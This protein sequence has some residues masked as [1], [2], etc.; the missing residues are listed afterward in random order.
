MPPLI[1]V[2]LSGGS[3]TRLWPLSREL[4]PKQ[5]LPLV[6]SRTLLQETLLRTKA[7][8][9][10]V[11]PPIVVCSV[12]HR[13]ILAEQL[14][15]IEVRPA[16]IVLEP[17]GRNTAPALAVA[18]LLAAERLSGEEDPLLVVLPAD[19][20]IVD[21]AAF[22]RAVATAADVA[23]LGRIVAFGIVPTGPETG[24]GYLLRGVDHG[25]WSEL[26]RFVEKP[27]FETASRFV[28]SGRY[29]WNSG[30]FLCSARTYLNELAQ[31]APPI[32]AACERAVQAADV[33]EDFTRL[34]A[35]FLDCPSSSIDY[36]V[37]EK[38]SKAAVVALDAGWSDIGSWATL[39]E[40]IGKDMDGNAF[41]GDVVAKECR[42]SYIAASSRLVAA[43][44][45]DGFVIVETADAVLV[46]P[47]ERAQS[48]KIIVDHLKQGGRA[49][50]RDAPPPLSTQ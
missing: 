6:T 26:E 31:H 23:T 16:M 28:E 45:L 30:M 25:G 34:G 8:E 50:V 22:A 36:A 39:H 38:T 5:L 9:T 48:V 7:F 12:D 33:D 10:A 35:S 17:A 44:G 49:E 43:I 24:Y 42:D 46:L 14:R 21:G 20:V 1:P 29:L 19:H 11:R 27:G 32:L 15:E 13:F 40:V 2:V 47:K 3:G 18:A 41:R 37:M 4:R